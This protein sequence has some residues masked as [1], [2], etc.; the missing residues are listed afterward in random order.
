M[1]DFRAISGVSKTL[2]S[3]LKTAT[4]VNVDAEK[5]PS[6][7]IPDTAALIHLYLYRVEQ[8]P[9]F[10][11]SDFI[12]VSDTLLQAPAIGINLFYLITP[13]GPDQLEV[14]KT[15]GDV[16]RSFH[17]TSIIPPVAFDPS[18]TDVTEE[19]RVIP[20]ALTLEQMTDLCRC[21]GQRP[22]RLSL[23][24]EVSVVLIASRTTR[25]VT[26]ADERRLKVGVLR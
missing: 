12:S 8:N 22:Y 25:A 4:G 5:A 9:A 24:Y 2:A 21:F 18:L 16:I 26:R 19:L 10:L 13:Y 15:L 1:S 6:D 11:N 3:F 20:H 17:E 7:S 14:Q 23:T